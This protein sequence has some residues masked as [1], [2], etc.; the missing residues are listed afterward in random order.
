M[1][2]DRNYKWGQNQTVDKINFLTLSER[3][4]EH[5][6]QVILITGPN[7]VGKSSIIEKLMASNR[8]YT[9]VNRT[10]TKSMNPN[11]SNYHSLD[12]SDFLDQVN[13]NKLLEWS[14]YGQGYYG[15]SLDDILVALNNGNRL[16]LDID[17]DG[18]LLLKDIFKRLNIP[19]YDCFI[20]PITTEE[21]EGENGVEKALEVISSRLSLRDR[22]E[23][24]VEFQGRIRNARA[25]LA[26]RHLFSNYI[27]NKDGELDQI[28]S[29][30]RLLV[31]DTP[32]S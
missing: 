11:E 31:G 20:S 30:L 4:G 14:K 28:I 24:E 18:A 19:I 5:N 12:E 2:L 27:S 15:T 8:G 29:Q 13:K 32:E 16:I 1:D 26:K 17:V 7:G 10:T 25:I 22:G 6:F 23:S 9:K 3:L 21:I